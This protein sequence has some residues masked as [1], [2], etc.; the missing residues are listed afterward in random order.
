VVI[1]GDQVLEAARAQLDLIALGSLDIA[2]P[3]RA[4]ADAAFTRRGDG[5]A[6]L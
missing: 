6:R 3:S 2:T 1:L 4:N 5:L